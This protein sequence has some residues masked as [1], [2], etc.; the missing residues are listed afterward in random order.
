MGWSPKLFSQRL[1]Q[2][3]LFCYCL[4]LFNAKPEAQCLASAM[5][6][7]SWLSRLWLEILSTLPKAPM[8]IPLCKNA[9]KRDVQSSLWGYPSWPRGVGSS[10]SWR[11]IRAF[12]FF[13][14]LVP[15]TVAHAELSANMCYNKQFHSQ[16]IVPIWLSICALGFLSALHSTCV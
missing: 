16:V 11:I 8:Q 14:L 15:L 1:V 12:F 5:C 10:K 9:T 13:E 3:L 6:A 2:K 7:L 4:S